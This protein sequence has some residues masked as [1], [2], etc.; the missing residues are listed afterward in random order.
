MAK[1][2]PIDDAL[3]ARVTK[4]IRDIWV[5]GRLGFGDRPADMAAPAIRRWQSSV[6]RAVPQDDG[7]ARVQ[8]LARGSAL[9]AAGKF[10]RGVSSDKYLPFADAIAEVMLEQTAP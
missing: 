3:L 4:V 8:D 6:R 1:N 5:G 7:Q 10:S 2:D 9:R